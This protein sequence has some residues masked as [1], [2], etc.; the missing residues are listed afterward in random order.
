MKN[1][2]E[3][4]ELSLSS[5][6]LLVAGLPEVPKCCYQASDVTRSSAPDALP[7]KRFQIRARR[8][9]APTTSVCI[10]LD[11]RCTKRP[12]T[13][14]PWHDKQQ[15][16]L[17]D[18]EFLTMRLCVE[19]GWKDH[20]QKDRKPR[21]GMPRNRHNL[22]IS[23]EPHRRGAGIIR[24]FKSQAALQVLVPSLEAVEEASLAVVDFEL[25]NIT[26]NGSA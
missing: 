13:R 17:D 18:R 6:S 8:M 21:H 12:R 23:L 5:V 22:V 1:I 4:M 11:D 25:H 20:Q 26:G 14:H 7:L 10:D 9:N 3:L 16:R 15:Q 19:Q 24:A 2:L